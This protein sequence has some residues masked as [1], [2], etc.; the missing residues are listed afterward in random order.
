[1]KNFFLF[2]FFVLCLL[3]FSAYS[4]SEKE[5]QVKAIVE[6]GSFV[7]R[8]DRVNPATGRS[9]T[10]SPFYEMSYDSTRVSCYL[11]YFGRSY[12]A[13]MDPRKLAIELTDKEVEPEISFNPRRGYTLVFTARTETNELITF[14]LRIS[15]SGMTT[16][17]INSSSRQSITYLGDLIM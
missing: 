9:I 14:Y 7:I 11:P 2:S 17:S 16:L 3:P 5:E 10:L 13:P 8:F 1:M 15:L 6:S 12:T 4:Q